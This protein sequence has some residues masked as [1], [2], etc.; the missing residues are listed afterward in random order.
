MGLGDYAPSLAKASN[1]T[2]HNYVVVLSNRMER[3]NLG[4]LS[5]R[6]NAFAFA[7]Y[8]IMIPNS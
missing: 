6:V 5:Y 1:T 3:F 7:F 8:E 2:P 4:N